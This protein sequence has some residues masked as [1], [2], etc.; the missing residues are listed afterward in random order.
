MIGYFD[1]TGHPKDPNVR[2]F[3]IIGCLGSSES[4]LEFD[5]RWSEALSQEG[6]EWFHAKDFKHRSGVF[7]GWAETRREAFFARLVEAINK[8]VEQLMGFSKW[9]DADRRKLREEYLLMHEYL[10]RHV[11]ANSQEKVNFVFAKHPEVNPLEHHTFLREELNRLSN[12]YEKIGDL[13]LSDPREKT[14]LQ[15]ADLIALEVFGW[16]S[17]NP[18]IPAMFRR[19]FAFRWV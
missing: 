19:P 8:H 11:V 5:R 2:S 17:D 1:E 4:W 15:A 13:T 9:L 7:A 18:R 3:G 16:D 12:H 14:P 10:V 6:V